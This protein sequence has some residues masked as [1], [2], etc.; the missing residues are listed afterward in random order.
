MDENTETFNYEI[1]LI[2]F[3]FALQRLEGEGYGLP[4]TID[5]KHPWG[6][7]SNELAIPTELLY[8]HWDD[9]YMDDEVLGIFGVES[10]FAI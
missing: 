4:P 3:A 1:V 9:N 2:V 5:V 10:P 6:I 8:E 7:L